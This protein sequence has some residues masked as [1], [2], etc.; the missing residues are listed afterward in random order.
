MSLK[1][2][3]YYEVLGVSR[4]A[5]QDEIRKAFRKLARKYHPDINKEKGAEDKFKILNEAYEVLEDPEKRKKYDALGANWKMG[6]EFQAPPGWENVRFNF[7]G[8]NGGVNSGG[9][10]EFGGFSDF[11]E[12]LFGGAATKGGMQGQRAAESIFGGMGGFG[13][14]QATSRHQEGRSHEGR[15][16]RADLTISL[17]D[18]Y[19]G[20]SRTIT[21][22]RQEKDSKGNITA[23]PKSYQVKI[24]PGTTEGAAIRLAGQ[25]EPGIGGAKPGDLLLQ[26]HIA[27]HPRFKVSGYD[28]ET[29]LPIAPWEASLG[30][31]IDFPLI[32]GRVKLKVPPGSQSASKLRLKGK[33]LPKKGGVAGDLLVELQISVP[34]QLSSGEREL[35]E[36]LAQVSNFNPRPF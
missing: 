16:Q 22:T 6:D 15:A 26:V 28:I 13:S 5:S 34:K 12:A 27:P 19:R 7:G 4:T 10:F 33:G 8:G 32:D 20:A 29:N 36:R 1:Y 31:E 30:A 25:G 2:Q 3:D 21:L 11:F 35:M 17:E 9:D 24:P 18:A 14:G 23:I